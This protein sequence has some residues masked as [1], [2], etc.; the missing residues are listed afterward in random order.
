VV[1]GV[2]GTK[3]YSYDSWGDAVNLASRLESHGHGGKIHVSREVFH[4]LKDRFAFESRG[5]IPIKGMGNLETY[6]M[7]TGDSQD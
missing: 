2:I 3:K 7:V 4:I 1:A 6:F 5:S